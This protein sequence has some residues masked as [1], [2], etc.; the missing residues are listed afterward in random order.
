MADP[1]VYPITLP[2]PEQAPV[3]PNDRA[4]RYGSDPR[5]SASFQRDF[6]GT[7]DLRFRFTADQAAVFQ[8]W[9]QTTLIYGGLFFAAD[10][11]LPAGVMTAV[12]R[13]LSPPS[14][15]HVA[16]G[17]WDVS[18]KVEIRGA[19]VLPNYYPLVPP[20][21]CDCSHTAWQANFE[22]GSIGASLPLLI[23]GNTIDSGADQLT[24]GSSSA[25]YGSKDLRLAF[26]EN[27]Q[28]SFSSP[29]VTV[30]G[31]WSLCFSFKILGPTSLDDGSYARF[32]LYNASSSEVMRLT[33]ES[34]FSGGFHFSYF[35]PPSF[36]SGTYSGFL[37]DTLYDCELNSGEGRYRF[38]ANGTQVFSNGFGGTSGLGS[39]SLEGG[40]P[41]GNP[42]LSFQFDEIRVTNV[43]EHT[44][45]YTPALPFCTC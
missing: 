38:Y 2:G 29:A 5:E 12:R 27:A 44:E 24:L 16:N 41:G 4:I 7:Q 1:V 40:G 39:L 34:D 11:P 43:V 8:A 37:Y 22:S 33:M 3:V 30:D 35:H 13:F 23:G 18:A 45:D 21:T 42:T 20:A 10:W 26:E 25:L 19:G 36:N 6:A 28:V 14:W 9:W 31:S 32:R 17:T 15:Q